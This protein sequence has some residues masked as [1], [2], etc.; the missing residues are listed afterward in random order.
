MALEDHRAD[1]FNGY[2][3]AVPNTSLIIAALVSLTLFVFLGLRLI[4]QHHPFDAPNAT[5]PTHGIAISDP[6]STF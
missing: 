5:A 6:W 3:G 4:N 1:G 2:V